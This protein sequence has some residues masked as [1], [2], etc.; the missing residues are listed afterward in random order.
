MTLRLIAGRRRLP[1]GAKAPGGALPARRTTVP[2]GLTD[3]P[4]ARRRELLV[5]L[6]LCAARERGARAWRGSPNDDQSA[7]AVPKS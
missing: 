6:E 7:A 3:D 4:A 5:V 2:D 1:A